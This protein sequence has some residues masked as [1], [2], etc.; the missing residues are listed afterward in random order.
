LIRPRNLYQQSAVASPRC[1]E[2]WHC[3]STLCC[4]N[5][6]ASSRPDWILPCFDLRWK[7]RRFFPRIPLIVNIN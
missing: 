3:L 6:S 5:L 1:E 2:R 7:S 4:G